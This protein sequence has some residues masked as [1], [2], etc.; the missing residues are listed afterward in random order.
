MPRLYDF[1]FDDLNAPNALNANVIRQGSVN[2]VERLH[3]RY[4]PFLGCMEYTLTSS[5]AVVFIPKQKAAF[6]KVAYETH[7]S[8]RH[9]PEFNNHFVLVVAAVLQR[10]L[11]L[12][13][14]LADHEFLNR[15]SVRFQDFIRRKTVPCV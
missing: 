3:S 10:V 8:D 14:N 11:C 6:L 7:K 15:T 2:L 12:P 4:L 9:I 1:F 13:R 5:Q